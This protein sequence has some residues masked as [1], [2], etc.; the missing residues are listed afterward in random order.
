[1]KTFDKLYLI[2][3]GLDECKKDE[4]KLISTWF[5]STINA[6]SVDDPEC[7]RCLFISQDD[8]DTC[9]FF[10]DIPTLHIINAN[11]KED[12]I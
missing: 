8:N 6:I 2:I 3:D 11:H 9:K 7:L 1:M 4:K 5:K 12:I 10:R